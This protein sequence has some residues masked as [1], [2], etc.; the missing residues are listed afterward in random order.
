[1]KKLLFMACIGLAGLASCRT[2]CPAYSFTKPATH[3]ATAVLASTA[4]PTPQ[5]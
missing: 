4:A 3:T 5:Q 2:K 1:M